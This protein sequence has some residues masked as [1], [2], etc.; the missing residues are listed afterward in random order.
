MSFLQML[1]ALFQSAPRHL[2]A[3][4]AARVRAGHAL[5]VDVRE[6]KEWAG[7]IAESAVL[8]PLSDLTGSRALWTEFLATTKGRE[9]L[10]YCVS[11]GRSG[12]AARIL[13]AEG[14]SAANTGGLV[15]W[16]DAGW[17]VT[18]PPSSRPRKC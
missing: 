6:P 13:V 12:I 10:L 7:G 1:K 4:C 11:G 15:D 8:L 14:V 16:A 18:Q 2:P 5:L 17:I 9:V 3:D